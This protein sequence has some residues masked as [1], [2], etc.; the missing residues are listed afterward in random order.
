MFELARQLPTPLKISS[1][2]QSVWCD[3]SRGVRSVQSAQT[4]TLLASVTSCVSSLLWAGSA[5]PA[6]RTMIEHSCKQPGWPP[7]AAK[8]ALHV[9]EGPQVKPERRRCLPGSIAVGVHAVCTSPQSPTPSPTHCA[10]VQA[11]PTWPNVLSVGTRPSSGPGKAPEGRLHLLQ[12]AVRRG[13]AGPGSLLS[14]FTPQ[15]WSSHKPLSR[16]DKALLDRQAGVGPLPP[17]DPALVG[18]VSCRMG[19]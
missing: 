5:C 13:S 18:H 19:H 10:C 7:H 1:I 17:P 6:Q 14:E 2:L 8:A 3:G 15:L 9:P 4:S 12:R 16:P 11:L